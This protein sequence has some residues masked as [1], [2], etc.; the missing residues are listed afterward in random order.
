MSSESREKMS[1]SRIEGFKN[2]TVVLYQEKSIHQYSLEGQYIQSFKSIKEAAEVT[3]ISR[4]SINRFLEGKYK[5][6][7]N[8]L[9]SLTK[10]T[11]LQPYCKPPK[12]GSYMNKAIRVTDLA[13]NKVIEYNSMTAFCQ[14]I[15]CTHSCIRH[16]LKYKHPYLRRYMIEYINA[17]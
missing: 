13:D 5:K 14:T 3:G 1:K 4:S 11:S 17:V 12:D 16:A 9:W 15:N 10:E 6:G 8:F 7:G 2:G